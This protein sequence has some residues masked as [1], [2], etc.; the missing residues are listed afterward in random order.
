MIAEGDIGYVQHTNDNPYHSKPNGT[1]LQRR[2]PHSISPF[3]FIYCSTP[4]SSVS[5]YLSNF[6]SHGRVLS[7]TFPAVHTKRCLP[8]TKA[9]DSLHFDWQGYLPSG[10]PPPY[11]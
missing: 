5:P 4:W 11:P 9:Y 10:H 2:V 1:Y 8:I 7:R 3:S 6:H